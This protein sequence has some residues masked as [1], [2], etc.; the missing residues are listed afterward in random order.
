MEELSQNQKEIIEMLEENENG[1]HQNIFIDKFNESP[2]SVTYDL[3][4]L[5]EKAELIRSDG[6][7]GDMTFFLDDD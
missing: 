7:D 3:W 4:Y 2:A 6:E 5:T 1:I